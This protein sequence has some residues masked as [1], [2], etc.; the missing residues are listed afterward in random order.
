MRWIVDLFWETIFLRKYAILMKNGSQMGAKLEPKLELAGC[1]IYSFSP[2]G[3]A[4]CPSSAKG[5]KK[6]SKMMPKVPKMT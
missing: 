5:A 6:V 3:R 2:L 4:G 1:H